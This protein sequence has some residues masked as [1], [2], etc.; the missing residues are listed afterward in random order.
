MFITRPGT[1]SSIQLRLSFGY[2]CKE[3]L[4]ELTSSVFFKTSIFGQMIHASNIV[5]FSDAIGKLKMERQQ[6]QLK[7]VNEFLS[8]LQKLP[9]PVP[10]RLLGDEAKGWLDGIFVLLWKPA[11]FERKQA[12]GTTFVLQKQTK[13]R[14]KLLFAISTGT[15]VLEAIDEF[16]SSNQNKT[17]DDLELLKGEWQM[18]SSSQ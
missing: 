16:I 14:Q 9:Y 1:A 4:S 3:H 7:T 8:N 13:P 5:R 17:E 6:H 15:G 2:N 11:K 18:M 12:Q 10:F